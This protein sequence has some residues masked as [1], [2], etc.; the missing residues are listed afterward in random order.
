M[1]E[2]SNVFLKAA[3]PAQASRFSRFALASFVCANLSLA[4]LVAGPWVPGAPYAFLCFIPAIILGH[5][6]RR[7]FRPAPG[8]FRN[9]PMATY[10]LA[11]GYL[12]LFL[13][14]FVISAMLFG[15]ITF[16]R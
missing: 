10:G 4:G 8:A 16:T 12:G 11:A 6:A 14:V 9:S 5:L 1:D 7:E 2:Q 13:S 15:V 3:Q